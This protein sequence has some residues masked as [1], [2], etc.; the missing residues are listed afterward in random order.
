MDP[1]TINEIKDKEK[2]KWNNLVSI[3]VFGSCV[4]NQRYNDIDLLMVIEDIGKNR[5]ERVEDIVEFKR[6]L[7]VKEPVD[8]TLLSKEE[9]ISNFSNH[10]PMYLDIAL[11]GQ[12]ILD[13]GFLK[14]LMDETVEYIK[15]KRIVR[16]GTKWIFPVG[17]GVATLSKITNKN[18]AESWLKDAERDLES[19]QI[20]YQKELFE[21]VVYHAQQ[22]VEKSIKAILI[23]F[24][25]FEKTHYVANGL[26]DE[27]EKR[28]LKDENLMELVKSSESL[29]PHVS[30]SRYPGISNN[31]IWLPYEEYNKD[32]AEDSVNKAG[33]AVEITEKFIEGWFRK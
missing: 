20:L 12:V 21:K 16:S 4:K 15:G 6:T 26:E 5:I 1:Q 8:I 30:L 22:C 27:I 10:N 31:E 25:E 3:A 9:C 28:D 2:K 14:D 29:E 11:D 18:W 23:C 17:R 7:N 13:N 24:G 33:K 19:A 32:M